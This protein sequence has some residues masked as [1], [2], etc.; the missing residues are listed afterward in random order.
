MKL[1]PQ[2]LIS[3]IHPIIGY[4]FGLLHYVVKSLKFSINLYRWAASIIYGEKSQ[5]LFFRK[6]HFTLNKLVLKLKFYS[7]KFTTIVVL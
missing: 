4:E 1:H 2:K 7:T 6:I 3:P 5:A